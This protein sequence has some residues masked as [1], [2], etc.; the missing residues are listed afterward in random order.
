MR[1][2]VFEFGALQSHWM[3]ARWDAT[4]PREVNKTFFF[5]CVA[6]RLVMFVFVLLSA[7]V[8]KR[9][10]RPKRSKDQ[11][12]VAG[13]QKKTPSSPSVYS[14]DA[15]DGNC[16]KSQWICIREMKCPKESLCG[17]GM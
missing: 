14:Q 10:S 8:L 7:V 1:I 4:Y 3:L 5:K 6:M 9:A 11:L 16:H 17:T 13:L 15:M 12:E 2:S